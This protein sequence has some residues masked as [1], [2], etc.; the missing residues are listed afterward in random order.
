MNLRQLAAIERSAPA[1]AVKALAAAH[2][3]ALGVGSVLVLE[4]AALVEVFRDGRRVVHEA[5]RPRVKVGARVKHA[6]S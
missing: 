5:V 3:R 6:T 4:D 2:R 1:R